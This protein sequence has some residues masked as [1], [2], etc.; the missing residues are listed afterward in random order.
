MKA[1]TPLT[2][3]YFDAKFGYFDKKF[4][5]IDGKFDVI[6]KKFASINGKFDAIDKRFDVVDKRFDRIETTFVT[7][8]LFTKEIRN[9]RGS[10]HQALVVTLDNMKEYYKEETERYIGALN[11]DAEEKRKATLENIDILN[12]RYSDHENRIKVLEGVPA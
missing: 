6:D 4:G 5:L 3:E 12:E 10:L 9:L 1:G 8:D 11:E 2:K 7:K